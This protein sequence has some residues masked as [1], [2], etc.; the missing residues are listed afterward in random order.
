MV[1]AAVLLIQIAS[2]Y[3]VVVLSGSWSMFLA[4]SHPTRPDL[5]S[6]HRETATQKCSKPNTGVA[7]I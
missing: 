7:K 3:H 1:Y 6:D 4:L 5:R 2:F